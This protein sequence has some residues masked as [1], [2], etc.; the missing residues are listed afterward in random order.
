MYTHRLWL[1]CRAKAGEGQTGGWIESVREIAGS[2][3]RLGVHRQAGWQAANETQRRV[4][5]SV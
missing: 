4:F 1:S 2:K 5:P 3:Q